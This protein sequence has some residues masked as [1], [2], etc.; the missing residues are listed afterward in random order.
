MFDWLW[1]A[2]GNV[3]L[4]IAWWIPALVGAGASVL[5]AAVPSM[6]SKKPKVD[7]SQF[8]IGAGLPG[9]NVNAPYF[10]FTEALTQ[11]RQTPAVGSNVEGR[12]DQFRGQQ[13]DLASML[14]E[15]AAGRGPSLAEALANRER[16]KGIAATLAAVGS[17]PGRPNVA[18]AQRLAASGT[19][20]ASAEA[21]RQAGAGGLQEIFAARDQLGN[22]LTQGRGGDVAVAQAMMASEEAKQRAIENILRIALQRELGA[23]ELS[24]K[25][26]TA[27]LAN[28]QAEAEAQ[29]RL[30]GGAIGGIGS[31]FANA[32]TTQV[33]R[34][35]ARTAV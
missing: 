12:S 6:L 20:G 32:L 35:R 30:I 14:G 24:G 27:R 18:M 5:S 16:E 9:G 3:D 15:T 10:N 21:S 34:Q 23:A 1:T 26:E 17:A 13:L 19:A 7:Q 31:S 2:P 29:R 25:G 28:E 33:P 11:A 8:Q 4:A 22:V